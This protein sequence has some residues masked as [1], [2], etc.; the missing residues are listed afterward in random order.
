MKRF[1]SKLLRL[2]LYK[3]IPS[4]DLIA[5][6]RFSLFR[7]LT[8]TGFLAAVMTALQTIVTFDT[9]SMLSYILLVLA[10]VLISNF[11]K[12]TKLEKLPLAYVITLLS[13]FLVVH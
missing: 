12:V 8:F 1:F 11:Y 3:T 4:D 13:G 7:I 9:H 6:Q 2:E 5:R 10:A